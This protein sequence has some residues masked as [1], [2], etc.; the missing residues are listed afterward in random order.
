MAPK[1]PN[2]DD[3]LTI[4][5]VPKTR[6]AI[7]MVKSRPGIFVDAKGKPVS[8][9]EAAAAGF[10]V[11]R[12]RRQR[13]KQEKLDSTRREL[14]R[15]I[16][17]HERKAA[18]MADPPFTLNE[19]GGGVFDILDEKGVF[20]DGGE[21]LRGRENAERMLNELNEVAFREKFGIDESGG[22]DE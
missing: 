20:V 13:E 19:R 12:L 21:K 18:F 8:D 6:K 7:H 9:E 17:F 1:P 2:P 14:E 4:R 3:G 22:E 11:E 10:D 15:E 16:E 5:M